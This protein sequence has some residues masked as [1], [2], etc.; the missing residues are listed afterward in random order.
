MDSGMRLFLLGSAVFFLLVFGGLT[1][2][3]LSSA[4][5]NVA[6]LVIGA[7]SLFV[8]GVVLLALIDAIRNPPEE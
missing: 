4:T 6:T 3:G 1:V 5:L 2:V 8:L 7:A